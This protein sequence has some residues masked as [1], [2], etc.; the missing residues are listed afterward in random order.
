MLQKVRREKESNQQRDPECPDLFVTICSSTF[1]M[2]R[3]LPES[4]VWE[5]VASSV[6]SIYMKRTGGII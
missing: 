1:V 6:D 4:H 2:R 5:Y 3:G